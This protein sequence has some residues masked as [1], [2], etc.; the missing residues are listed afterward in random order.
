MESPSWPQWQLM[1]SSEGAVPSLFKNL[2][3]IHHHISSPLP[4]VVQYIFRRYLTSEGIQLQNHFPLGYNFV[5]SLSYIRLCWF[6]IK[7]WRST[8]TSDIFSSH[9]INLNAWPF[10]TIQFQSK[11]TQSLIWSKRV[12][13]GKLFTLSFSLSVSVNDSGGQKKRDQ[14][15]ICFSW[16]SFLVTFWLVAFLPGSDEVRDRKPAREKTNTANPRKARFIQQ[17]G[18]IRLL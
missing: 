2:P 8:R 17:N 1:T 4:N 9:W 14:K 3:D 18:I 10:T 11:S 6:R 12:K 15:T 5:F 16:F 13:D 7:Y